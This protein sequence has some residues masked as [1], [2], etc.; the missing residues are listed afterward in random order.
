MGSN[1]QCCNTSCIPSGYENSPNWC[2]HG[3]GIWMAGRGPAS[4]TL[5]SVAHAY[6]GVGNGA[7]QQNTS[8]G[9]LLSYIAN[10]GES[11]IDFTFSSGSRFDSS[12]SQYFTPYG[13]VPVEPPLG[14][15]FGGHAVSYTYQGLN[16]NDRDMG[17]AGVLLFDDLGSNHRVV[18][19]DKSGYCYLLTQG[20]LCGSV[21]S[22]TCYP[23]YSGST[24]SPTRD[25]V[26]T[27]GHHLHFRP[28]GLWRISRH[29]R[30]GRRPL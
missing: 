17:V 18:T 4:N 13:G 16:Q 15:E 12:P 23:G 10:W 19:C 8:G 21:G 30:Q 7:F 20:N 24:P 9:A 22:I 2:G 28:W 29:A 25:H 14:A 27:H 11:V 5:S 26:G 1:P 3:G 6:F